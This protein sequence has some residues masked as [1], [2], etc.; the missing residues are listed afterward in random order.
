MAALPAALRSLSFSLFCPLVCT[1]GIP[2]GSHV[3]SSTRTASPTRPQR[4]RGERA[5]E[6]RVGLA[7]EKTGR[8]PSR[9]HS[10]TGTPPPCGIRFPRLGSLSE[11]GRSL[12]NQEG[13]HT[14]ESSPR[15]QRSSCQNYCCPRIEGEE[16]RAVPQE[17]K[18]F[19][20]FPFPS[21]RPRACPFGPRQSVVQGL[22]HANWEGFAPLLWL[23]LQ[24]GEEVL[25]SRISVCKQV[26]LLLILPAKPGHPGAAAWACRD[27]QK[28]R[29][30]WTPHRRATRASVSSLLLQ[31]PLK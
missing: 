11:R 18:P 26:M 4:G 21:L 12:R 20:L 8:P 27:P 6:H 7:E 2:N 25:Q 13:G 10:G 28:Q 19:F 14:H 31:A 24:A 23:L 30:T 1:P 29:C 15:R 16:P 9:K 17:P 3:R 22:T 5:A